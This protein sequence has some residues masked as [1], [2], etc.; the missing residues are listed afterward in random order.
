MARAA[1]PK[2]TPIGKRNVLTVNGRDP[3]FEYRWVNDE[4]GRLQMFEEA[5]YAAVK[6]SLE[7]GDP[8]AGDA[9]Q[10]GSTVRKP[11][12]GGE[13][14]VLMKIPKEF[15]AEDQAAKEQRLAEKERSLLNDA[16]G[17][18]FY[19]DGLKIERPKVQID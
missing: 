7:V 12:G 3:G 8:R 6:D 15:Y 1:R 4:D 2:R 19:G 17:N 14:A 9:S 11:V 13:T 18:G 5:G 10:V 16:K